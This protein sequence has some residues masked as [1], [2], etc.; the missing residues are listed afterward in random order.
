MER[1]SAGG[2]RHFLSEPLTCAAAISSSESRTAKGCPVN[3]RLA[4]LLQC[5]SCMVWLRAIV[6]LPG[7]MPGLNV[8]QELAP[9]AGSLVVLFRCRSRC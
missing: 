6:S 2:S 7:A 4:V 9:P 5:A 8:A 3:V 1:E